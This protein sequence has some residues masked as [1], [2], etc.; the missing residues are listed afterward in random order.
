MSTAAKAVQRL[1]NASTEAEL[2]TILFEEADLLTPEADKLLATYE[3]EARK[4]GDKD[5]AAMLAELRS[6]LRDLQ[7]AAAYQ[8]PDVPGSMVA[9]EL[10]HAL[11]TIQPSPAIPRAA[12]DSVFAAT[13]DSMRRHATQCRLTPMLED[14]AALD[15]RIA[16]AGGLPQNSLF[17]EIP[18]IHATIAR[19]IDTESWLDSHAV[20]SEHPELKTRDATAIVNLLL[21]AARDQGDEEGAALFAQHAAILDQARQGKLEDAYMSLLV[22]EQAERARRGV[23]AHTG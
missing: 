11:M 1:L 7:Q 10:I 2:Q 16:K 18:S 4:A 19:W 13:L 14:L 21:R 20:I 6:F 9:F 3:R 23:S 12:L 22:E 5:P 17:A 15:V 8:P